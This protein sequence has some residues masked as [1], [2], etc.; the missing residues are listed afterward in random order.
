M[1]INIL[2][3]SDTEII[4]LLANFLPKIVWIGPSK[5]SL[6]P[7]YLIRE[8]DYLEYTMTNEAMRSVENP[9]SY[10]QEWKDFETWITEILKESQ[11]IEVAKNTLQGIKE[12]KE[13]F[14]NYFNHELLK[15]YET[16]FNEHIDL[17]LS[18][19]RIFQQLLIEMENQIET[20]K[21]ELAEFLKKNKILIEVEDIAVNMIDSLMDSY[22]DY[23]E[24]S[25]KIDMEQLY[26]NCTIDI[27]IS[28]ENFAEIVNVPLCMSILFLHKKREEEAERKEQQ[29]IKMEKKEEEERI[30]REV[31]DNRLKMRKIWLDRFN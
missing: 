25:Y 12:T 15:I 23:Y 26:D 2:R 30:E 24:T 11:N 28:A 29:R 13:K 6:Q 7:A 17:F 10:F 9:E 27:D 20:E 16:N 21:K 3:N 4:D 19:K 1:S 8:D 18:L 14:N 31:S 22:K 5:Q